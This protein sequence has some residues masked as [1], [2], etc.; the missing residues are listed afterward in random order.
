MSHKQNVDQMKPEQKK[1]RAWLIWI[2]CASRRR[3]GGCLPGEGAGNRGLARRWCSVSLLGLCGWDRDH[4]GIAH[5]IIYW[6]PMDFLYMY[7]QP[8]FLNSSRLIIYLSCH[9]KEQSF[10]QYINTGTFVNSKTSWNAVLV[11]VGDLEKNLNPGFVPLYLHHF[12]HVVNL[13]CHAGTVT[14]H[15]VC[16][17]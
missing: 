12:S 2:T 10:M 4:M 1:N 9:P 13:I 15:R 16:E 8:T 11:K 3:N 6:G 14:T 17:I 7:V 5:Q